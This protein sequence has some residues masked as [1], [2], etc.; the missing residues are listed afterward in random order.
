MSAL[1]AV[2]LWALLAEGYRWG[3]WAWIGRRIVSRGR[4]RWRS[5]TGWTIVPGFNDALIHTGAAMATAQQNALN[6]AGVHPIR[7]L[8]VTRWWRADAAPLE[9]APARRFAIRPRAQMTYEV[10]DTKTQDIVEEFTDEVIARDFARGLDAAV[11][12]E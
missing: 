5:K 12:G 3:L 6:A 8:N 10:I 7:K 2:L 9:F 4:R 11:T 1:T